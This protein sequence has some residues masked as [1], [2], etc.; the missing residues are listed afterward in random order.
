MKKI[1]SNDTYTYIYFHIKMD[2]KR[3]LNSYYDQP[4]WIIQNTT[5][6]VFNFVIL[7][8]TIL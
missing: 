3:N 1:F 5:K 4:P 6:I 2:T 8:F 7:K